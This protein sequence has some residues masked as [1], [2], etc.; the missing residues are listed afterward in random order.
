MSKTALK[1]SKLPPP[2]QGKTGR[3]K[4]MSPPTKRTQE[5][6]SVKKMAK[7]PLT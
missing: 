6:G 3:M 4:R 1:S 7:L 5:I 2:K